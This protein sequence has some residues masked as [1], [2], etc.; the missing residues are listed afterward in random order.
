VWW[1]EDEMEEGRKAEW[2]NLAFLYCES[3]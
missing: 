3:D 2:R 1:D